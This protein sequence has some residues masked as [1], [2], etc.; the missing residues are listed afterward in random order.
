MGSFIQKFEA[1]GIKAEDIG[2]TV[3]KYALIGANVAGPTVAQ[4]AVTLIAGAPAGALAGALVTSLVNA[5]KA[6]Q[7]K[8]A[9]LTTGAASTLIDTRKQDVID[10]V[11]AF[12]PVAEFGLLKMGHPV[13][14]PAAFEAALPQMID[15]YVKIID[16]VPDAI[17]LTQQAIGAFT[18]APV[19]AVVPLAKAA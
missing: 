2:K 18:A 11:M 7:A 12:L 4:E 9:A 1:V 3:G 13:A 8:K 5:E 17:S 14:N 15:T 16:L 19:A 6:H 10:N